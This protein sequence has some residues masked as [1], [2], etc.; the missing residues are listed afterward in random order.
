MKHL[1]SIEGDKIQFNP[2]TI[3]LNQYNQ[4]FCKRTEALRLESGHTDITI[5]ANM[6]GMTARQYAKHEASTPLP[7][8][9]IL[10]FCS[11]TKSELIELFNFPLEH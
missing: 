7:H 11:I 1:F 5:F 4:A 3:T 8:C 10:L 6:L 2:E 9:L